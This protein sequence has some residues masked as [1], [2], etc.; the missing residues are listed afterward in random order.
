MRPVQ[1]VARDGQQ[2]MLFLQDLK[3]NPH[4]SF[5]KRMQ[6]P[7]HMATKREG[8]RAQKQHSKGHG[9]GTKGGGSDGRHR[10][11]RSP[12]NKL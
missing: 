12:G 5:M 8:S 6:R 1:R 3:R 4:H 9:I 7:T 11:G 2:P 10:C